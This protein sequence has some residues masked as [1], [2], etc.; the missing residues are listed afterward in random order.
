MQTKL[1]VTFGIAGVAMGGLVIVAVTTFSATAAGTRQLADR[2][3]AAQRVTAQ[4]VA[5]FYQLDGALNMYLLVPDRQSQPALDSRSTY[6]SGVAR[7]ADARA[8]LTPLLAGVEETALADKID[9][10]FAG[11]RRFVA[12][13]D[14]AV[15]VGDLDAAVQAQTI[16]N[17]DVSNALMDALD[18][19]A[20]RQRD[21]SA[22]S[23]DRVVGEAQ[24]GSRVILIA[25]VLAVLLGLVA[26]TA[27]SKLLS[28]EVRKVSRATRRLALGDVAEP[29]DVH[30]TDELGEMADNLRAVQNY[31]RLHAATAQAIASGDLTIETVPQ[32]DDDVLGQS[33]RSMTC[34][35]RELVGELRTSAERVSE[36]A[37]GL[38]SAAQQTGAVVQQV[39]QA[40]QS[41]ASGASDTSA[42]ATETREAVT[43]LSQVTDGIARGAADQ[44][45]QVNA[46]SAA[47]RRM[48]SD[49]QEI[50]QRADSVAAATHQTRASAESGGLAVRDTAAA[51]A[52]IKAVVDEAADHVQQLGKLGQRIGAV[53]DTIDDIAEQTNLL[54]LNAAI[55]AAR[56]GEHGKGFA[57]V[58]DEVRKLAERSG[59]ETK[60]IAELIR[61]VQSGTEGAVSAMTVGA[62][63]V[64]LGSERS[65]QAARALAEI[66]A[67][68]E[69][70]VGQVS[71][72]ADS[73]R[74]MA[75]GS[76]DVS[77]AMASIS[78]VVE[79]NTAS[80]EEMAAR[81]E[82]LADAIRAIAAVAEEQ[83]AST[84]EVSASA[85]EM[86]ASTEEM[87]A[88]AQDLAATAR[89]LE[90]LV[91]RFHLSA[92]AQPAGSV[93]RPVSIAPRRR[94]A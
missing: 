31:L 47:A 89:Q 92:S 14:A 65:Q 25:G 73:A 20:T 61:Q 51:M 70:T 67:A 94:A 36:T 6:L 35:I 52:E 32:S 11:Y 5:A 86:S 22:A 74:L 44:A 9:T 17:N 8:Q 62:Q 72:I 27:L 42:N 2:D 49:V 63:K 21:Q 69:T 18:T 78:A 30:S 90:A 91:A 76:N 50:A 55:E 15:G 10:N 45:E 28:G 83:S 60:Q 79:E 33:L 66:L 84:E 41:V 38:E 39:A 13:V 77:A 87:G 4:M 46:G 68:V 80:T 12:T 53:V 82:Q 37:S 71:E 54:A 81:T 88:Q 48:A 26:T 93:V 57:V 59:R 23:A 43:Q 19:L 7:F 16:D 58:A 3:G 34:G 75:N 40:M 56:A 24:A 29:V 85:E 1:W 64:V